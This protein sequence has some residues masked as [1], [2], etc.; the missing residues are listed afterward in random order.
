NEKI[1]TGTRYDALRIVALDNWKDAKP[2]LT[3]YLART[4]HA[5]LQQGAVSGLVDVE[6]TGADAILVM[7]LPD[8]TT[9]NRKFAIE[10]LLRTP[11]RANSLLDTIEQSH[12]KAEWLAKE[13]RDALIKHKDDGIR[14][15]A[16]KLLGEK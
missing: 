9:G 4:A 15:R 11:A 8:L 3:K 13:H 16:A 12:A 10:G 14:T 2:R 5:E 6:D 7:G 1:P